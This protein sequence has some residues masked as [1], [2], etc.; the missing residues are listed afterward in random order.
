MKQ[1]IKQQTAQL[2]E[3]GQEMLQMKRQVK[4]TQVKE[5]EKEN[6]ILNEQIKSYAS[7]LVT[8]NSEMQKS[9]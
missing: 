9:H 7:R 3:R 4:Y 1:K 2:E 6:H 8:Q 5:I